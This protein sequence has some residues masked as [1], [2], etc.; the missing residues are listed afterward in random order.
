VLINMVMNGMDAVADLPSS[1]RQVTVH[2]RANGGGQVEIAVIDSGTGVPEL[3][4]SRIFEPFFTTKAAGMGMGLSV[5]RTIVDAH[6]GKLWAEN[7]A[8]GGATFRV[9]LPAIA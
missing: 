7:R 3:I 6:G 1:M 5:S 2:A 4:L 9:T 8:E